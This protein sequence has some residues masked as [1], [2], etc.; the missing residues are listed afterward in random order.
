M[1]NNPVYLED[2]VV[3]KI[4]NDCDKRIYMYIYTH[5]IHKFGVYYNLLCMQLHK[6]VLICGVNNTFGYH[7]QNVTYQQNLPLV[8]LHIFSSFSY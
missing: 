8:M 1:A 5:A 4:A 6:S 2:N 3:E 7:N